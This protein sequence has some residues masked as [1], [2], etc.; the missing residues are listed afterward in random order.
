MRMAIQLQFFSGGFDAQSTHLRDDNGHPARAGQ[1]I[2]CTTCT[3]PSGAG[4]LDV[5]NDQAYFNGSHENEL[6][7]GAMKGLPMR[8]A[9]DGANGRGIMF[10]Y[11][12]DHTT[13]SR[14]YDRQGGFYILSTYQSTYEKDEAI[15]TEL[16]GA[17]VS[18]FDLTGGVA[19]NKPAI[20]MSDNAFVGQIIVMQG[21][22]II[23]DIISGYRRMRMVICA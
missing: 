6:L 16:D 18:S 17:L 21:A 7:N 2:H 10:A 13:P 9:A 4:A 23:G 5:Q 12:K 22:S 15:W 19:G 3:V 11:G 14:R 8:I 1:Y 20:D